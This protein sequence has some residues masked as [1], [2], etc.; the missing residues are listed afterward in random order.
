MASRQLLQM[1]QFTDSTTTSHHSPRLPGGGVHGLP[2]P[3][4]ISSPFSSRKPRAQ[5]SK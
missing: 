2:P 4:P 5:Y 1:M 3:T